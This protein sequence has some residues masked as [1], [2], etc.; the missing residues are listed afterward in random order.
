[1][2][3]FPLFPPHIQTLVLTGWSVAVVLWWGLIAAFC[4]LLGVF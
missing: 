4:A 2:S 3:D 1:M